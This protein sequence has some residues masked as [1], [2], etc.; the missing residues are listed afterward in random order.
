MELFPCQADIFLYFCTISNFI[1]V[2]VSVNCKV[3]YISKL[4]A[5]KVVMDS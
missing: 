4:Y 1:V 5:L 2:L 3:D